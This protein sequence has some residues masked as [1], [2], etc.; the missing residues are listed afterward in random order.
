MCTAHGK[1]SIFYDALAPDN[2]DALFVEDY[3]GHWATAT[4]NRETH[5]IK[6]N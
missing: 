5:Y 3:D 1:L 6:Q 2:I 4:I